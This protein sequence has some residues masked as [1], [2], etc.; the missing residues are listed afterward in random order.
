MF[1]LLISIQSWD[2]R[3]LWTIEM[4][5]FLTKAKNTWPELFYIMTVSNELSYLL[6]SIILLS[7]NRVTKIF[8]FKFKINNIAFTKTTVL[9]VNLI[10]TSLDCVLQIDIPRVVC[11]PERWLSVWASLASMTEQSLSQWENTPLTYLKNINGLYYPSTRINLVPSM[12]C[13][14]Y[15]IYC[16]QINLI[17]VHESVIIYSSL[18]LRCRR[19]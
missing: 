2:I 8:T 13:L 9:K 1:I 16:A 19:V 15:V 11:V 10:E 5:T 6:V 4:Q 18:S 7:Q 12:T 14:W 3:S 17:C